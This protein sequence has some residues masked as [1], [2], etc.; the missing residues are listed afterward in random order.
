MAAPP[1]GPE[2]AEPEE[3]NRRRSRRVTLL[4]L[5]LSGIMATLW[6]VGPH[7]FAGRDDPT[8]IDSKPVRE[9]VQAGCTQLRADLAAVPAG[10]AV[11]ERAEAE[12]RAVEQFVGKVRALGPDALARDTPVERWLSDWEQIVGARRAAGRDGKRFTVPL[13]DN[14]PVN[15]RMYALIRSGLGKCDVP[16]SL[17][18]PEPGRA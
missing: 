4:V 18:V 1:P 14:G 6:V 10:L 7:V 2:P 16:Q 5:G 17:L 3:P 12:N 9:T 8:A 15:V 13:A 11:A